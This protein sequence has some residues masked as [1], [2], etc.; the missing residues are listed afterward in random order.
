MGS[1]RLPGKSMLALAGKPLV[2]R[3]LERLKRCS[4]VQRIVLAVPNTDENDVLVQLAKNINV[5]YYSGSENNLIDRFYKAALANN[6]DY[7][8]RFPADN[9]V[10]EPKE[11]DK[12]ISFHLE[13]NKDGFSSNICSFFGSGYPDGIGAEIFS[14][15]LLEEVYRKETTDEQKE[16]LHLNFFN[17]KNSKPFDSEWC[18]VKTFKCHRTISRPNLILDVNTFEQYKFLEDIYDSLYSVNS[19]FG[20][21]DIIYW[22]DNIYLK[23]FR[24]SKCLD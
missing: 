12:L 22:Y 20:I 9:P 16:H 23:K 19:N 8:V 7:I 17:Y 5:N 13:N 24:N 2:Y 11:I 21:E 1:T 10:P 6:A 3:I 4:K 14:M 15:K 18:Q